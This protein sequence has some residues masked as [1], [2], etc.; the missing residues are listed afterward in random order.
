MKFSKRKTLE[1][2]EKAGNISLVTEEMLKD[3]DNFDGCHAEKNRWKALVHD[4]EVYTVV[5]KDGRVFEF[6]SEMIEG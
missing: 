6:P 4:E 2:I 5:G 1:S 3:M